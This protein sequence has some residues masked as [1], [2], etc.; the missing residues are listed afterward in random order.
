[1]SSKALT[2]EGWREVKLGEVAE[3]VTGKTPPTKNKLMYGNRYPFITPTDIDERSRFC[4]PSRYLSKEGRDYQSSLILPKG[5]ICYT[6]I[7]SI[8]KVC[9]TM[10]E[11]F[12]NQQ[13]NSLKVYAD[14]ANSFYIFYYLRHITPQLE[15]IA[16]GTTTGI[17][18]KTS[19]SNTTIS[20]PPLTE[21][22]V[23]AEILSSLDDKIDLLRRQNETLETMAQTLFKQWFVEEAR[24]DWEDGRI[25]DLINIQSGFAFKSSDFVENGEYKLITIKNVQNGYLDLSQANRLEKPERGVVERYLLRQGDILLSLTGNVGRCCLTTDENLLLN[26]RVAK[27]QP[28]EETNWAFTYLFFRRDAMRRLLEETAKGTAQPNLS[29]V[30][31]GNTK[32]Q[33]PPQ[34]V[35]KDFSE[36]ATPMLEKVLSNHS[37]ICKLENTRD[38]LLPK[39]VS[40]EA[41]VP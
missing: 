27:L 3:I 26:Q 21:Q 28:K 35:L 23:I 15:S 31:T 24:D 19:F 18:N 36:Q 12:T 38:I 41:R 40:G 32:I 1:M 7:A 30:E 10:E 17:I 5:T 2:P 25:S 39:L 34:D 9:I 14:I 8:G 11:S 6:C 4:T 16:G 33:I 13:I 29:P 22:K 20:L 37:R